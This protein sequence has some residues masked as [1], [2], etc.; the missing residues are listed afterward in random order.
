MA[1]RELGI[2]LHGATGGV[3]SYQHL[4]N[5]LAPIRAEGGLP[6]GEDVIM[7]KL[8]L[9]GRNPE[10]LAEVAAEN[11]GLGWTADLDSALSDPGYPVFF[12]AAATHQRVQVLKR[13]IAAGKHIYTEKPVAPSAEEGLAL[14]RA[15]EAKGLKHGAVEDKLFLP[16]FRKLRQLVESG[17][18]GRIIGFHIE[19]GWWV[20]DGIA[21]KSQRPSWNYRKAGGGGLISDMHPHWRYVIEG[22]LGP[23]E[24]VAAMSWTGQTDRAGEAGGR[25]G[26]DV[27]DSVHTLV[28]LAGGARGA[29]L[30]SWSTRVR[31]D[32]LVTFQVDGTGGSAAAGLRRCWAQAAGA[33]PAIRGFLMGRDPGTMQVSVD[34]REGWQ[35]VPDAGPYKNPYRFGWEGFIRHV[36]AG[37]PFDA[38]LRAGIR[39]V[40][41]AE[42]CQRSAAEGRWIAMPRL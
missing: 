18:F 14:L 28:E 36:A 19:F 8:L 22:I 4:R 32:D 37:A 42:A 9:A 23:I 20:F 39:D 24:R 30:S 10:R 3:C 12:D 6:A 29:I 16:G 5:S 7:P 26:V 17:F 33:T 15:A 34:Y 41:L 13:A 40:Q 25:F 11:G 27:E 38:D 21:A 2:I 35:E 1:T 31:R